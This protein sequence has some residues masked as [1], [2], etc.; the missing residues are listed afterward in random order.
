MPKAADVAGIAVERRHHGRGA[1]TALVSRVERVHI[2]RG[3]EDVQVKTPG[4]SRPCDEYELTRRFYEKVGFVGLEEFAGLWPDTPDLIS[5]K[6][7]L[8]SP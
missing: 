4:P 2:E 8:R 7:L 3:V 6:G 1:G 5:V